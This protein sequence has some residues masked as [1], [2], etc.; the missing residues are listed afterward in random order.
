VTIVCSRYEIFGYTLVE[1]MS[2]GCPV[3][4]SA[5]GGMAE[6]VETASRVC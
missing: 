5:A 3:V 1:A 4:A 2:Q 6:L